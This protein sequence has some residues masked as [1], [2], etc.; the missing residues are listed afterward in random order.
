MP[1]E[2]A[3]VVPLYNEAENVA[4]LVDEL[5]RVF[6]AETRP[7]EIVLVDDGSKDRTWPVI[8]EA[9]ARQP[10]VHG[11]RHTQNRGQ[12]AAVW[13]G[14]SRTTAPLLCT[15]DGDLQNDPSELPRM[16]AMLNEL[17]FVSGH[18]VDRQDSTLR[19]ISSRI[20]RV[21][22]KL[23]LQADFADTGCALRAFK[24]ECL[25]GLFPFNGL[26]R[27]LPILVAG[28]GFRC[29]EVPVKHRPRVAGVSK[30][31]VWNR[32]G[33]GIYDLIGVGWFQ[34]RRIAMVTVADSRE[35][36]P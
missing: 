3:I 1:V 9:Q 33:R 23:A 21:A 2:I 19:Q 4:P 5:V 16:L 22:R 20:A 27:F 13:T 8:L 11:L 10:R 24:R 28:G 29:R 14:L 12:S 7:W 26:H 31:G 25:Q 15:L 35:A 17:D 6:T 34:R 32:L 30:Y 18:R 36:S